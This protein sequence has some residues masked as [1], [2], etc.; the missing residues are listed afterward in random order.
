MIKIK[1]TKK[2]WFLNIITFLAAFLLF[3]IELIICKCLLNKFGGT[4]AVWGAALVFFSSH[5]FF[6]I[7]LFA[8]SFKKIQYISLPI[9]SFIIIIINSF[10]PPL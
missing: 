10:G 3:Q 8:L 1:K 4:Y 9:F 6:R 7:P 5:S 2:I